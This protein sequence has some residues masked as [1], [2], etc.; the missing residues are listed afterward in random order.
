MSYIINK[1]DGTVLTEVVDGTIDQVSTDITLVGK[2]ATSYGESVN[3]N[4]VKILENFA[5][6]TQPNNPIKGQ[7][8]YDTS[9]GR[10]KVYDGL[11]FKVSGGTI[12]SNS[13]PSSFAQGDIWIDSYR[14]QMYFNDGS[15]AGQGL[16]AGPSYTAQQ[17]LSGFRI[18]DVIDTDQINR[19]VASLYVAQTLIGIY[20]KTAFTP[21][22]A[23]PGFVGSIDVGFNA[24]NVSGIKSNLPAIKAYNL[25]AAD[26]SL[27]SAEDFVST[28][29]DSTMTGTLTLTN[30]TSLILGSNQSN[31]INSTGA[32]FNIISQ[33]VNQNFSINL[34]NGSGIKPGFF[35]NAQTECIGLYTNTPTATLDVAGDVKIQGDLIVEGATTTIN[36][37][38]IS[39]ED[40]LI[41][42]GKVDNPNNSTADG[43]GIS[44]AAGGD[45]DKTITWQTLYSGW[46]S[47]ESFRLASGKSYKIGSAEVLTET[48]LGLSVASAPGLT[49]VGI[50]TGLQV[51]NLSFSGNSISY[52][53]PSFTDGNVTLVPKGDGVVDVS[54][55]QISNVSDPA[56]PLDA[57]NKQTL[58][59]TVQTAPLGLSIN[60]GTLTDT[61]IITKI[62][63]YIY[64]VNEHQDGTKC[65]IWCIDLGNTVK[66][67]ILSGGAWGHVT[68]DTIV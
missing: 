29:D 10:L 55:S 59:T 35:I 3:E 31:Q 57:V 68:P 51:V 64:P 28:T 33:S 8:W 39:I 44:L 40:L 47:S 9:E 38:N 65:R 46:S 7:L 4:F 23:I 49:S 26:L 54:N 19:T 45:G 5:S 34:L 41:E 22:A 56:A 30:P 27:K 14:Q 37:T 63:N 50:L 58:I 6:T 18:E 20:S 43:G 60:V 25:V 52:V 1:T 67:F 32:S 42:L 11:G 13:I 12:V 17:G 24:A 2:N 66:T 15:V 53:H 16:L 48:S 36:T 61:Q 21:A 62:I